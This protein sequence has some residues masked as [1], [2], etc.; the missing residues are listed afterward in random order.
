[1]HA[2]DAADI[3]KIQEALKLG[4]PKPEAPETYAFIK[5]L[6]FKRKGFAH[7]RTRFVIFLK[8]VVAKIDWSGDCNLAEAGT[9]QRHGKEL[10]LAR[11]LSVH[12]EGHLLVMARAA[13][14]FFEHEM[15][16][17]EKVALSDA[18]APFRRALPYRYDW[19]YAFNW[20]Y[21]GKKLVCID[22]AD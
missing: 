1:M 15:T 4:V 19:E 8:R 3:L 16:P 20:G 7:G 22:Y 2:N 9:F 13:R 11:V 17:E 6:G 21:V 18:Q 10:P 14:T 12:A 5:R